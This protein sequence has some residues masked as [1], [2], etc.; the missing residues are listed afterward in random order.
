MDAAG[1]VP[2]DFCGQARRQEDHALFQTDVVFVRKD[3]SLRSRRKFWMDEVANAPPSSP[4]NHP[5]GS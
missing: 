5:S 2:Y 1:F 4:P 3:S